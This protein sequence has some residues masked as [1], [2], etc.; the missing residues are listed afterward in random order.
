MKHRALFLILLFPLLLNADIDLPKAKQKAIDNVRG[1]YDK[2]GSEAISCV[3]S[4]D[5]KYQV[6]PVSLGDDGKVPVPTTPD[7]WKKLFCAHD[8]PHQTEKGKEGVVGMSNQDMKVGK[9]EGIQIAAVNSEDRGGVSVYDPETDSICIAEASDQTQDKINQECKDDYV[10]TLD[11]V[12]GASNEGGG[13]MACLLTTSEIVEKVG[14]C[15]A[16]GKEI[17]SKN[18]MKA[19]QKKAERERKVAEEAER[20]HL[21]QIEAQRKK[22]Q[23]KSDKKQDVTKDE[24]QNETPTPAPTT[25]DVD[26][27]TLNSLI[28]QQVSLLRGIIASGQKATSAQ[29]SQFNSLNSQYAAEFDRLKAQIGNISDAAIRN[30]YYSQLASINSRMNSEV[31]PLLAQGQSLGYFT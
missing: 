16:I 14:D 26:F 27:S 22:G 29:Q 23:K 19:Q 5:G 11:Y 9:E 31:D 21:Q 2:T 18:K 17:K 6:S 3:Y 12:S 15:L 28:S 24:P 13:K 10:T 7:G 20:L 8:G 1:Q 4:K 30:Q 25:A